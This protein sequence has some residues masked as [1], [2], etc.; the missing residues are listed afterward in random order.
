MQKL[1]YQKVYHGQIILTSVR[2]ATMSHC[3]HKVTG[4]LVNSIHLDSEQRV[5]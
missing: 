2:L 4:S 1:D 3:T 5:K